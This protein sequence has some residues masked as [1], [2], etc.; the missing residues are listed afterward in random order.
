MVANMM[1]DEE[2]L[3]FLLEHH[4]LIDALLEFADTD[5]FK[6]KF[7]GLP[8]GEVLKRFEDTLKQDDEPDDVLRERY[9]RMKMEL[10][11][12]DHRVLLRKLRGSSLFD[13]LNQEEN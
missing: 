11:T 2:Q 7:D 1:L 6:S 4:E 13:D 12:G 9:E 5:E 8:I 3:A 10:E